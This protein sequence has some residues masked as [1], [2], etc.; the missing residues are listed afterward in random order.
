VTEPLAPIVLRG[1]SKTYGTKKAVF[2]TDLTISQATCVALVGPSGSGKSTLLRLVLG[3]VET[4]TGSV[5]VLGEKMLAER[6]VALRRRI[7]YVIQ[8]GGL[9]P[10]LSARDNA[11]LVA[12]YIGWEESRCEKRLSGLAELV[13]LTGAIW[14]RYPVELSGGERQRVSLVRA[15]ML[16]PEVLLLDEPLGALDPVRR[17]H[18]QDDL[19][20]IFRDLQKTVMLVTHDLAE[21]AYLADEIAVMHEGALLQKGSF[22]ELRARPS[23]EMVS[24]FLRAQRLESA[25]ATR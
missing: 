3:L 17:A 5:M 22:E 13:G 2:P 16:D 19:R 9:F 20:A 8:D 25:E 24:E 4:D 11:T 21:A 1:V 10:H 6:A 7:G 18:L 12:R 23:H 15:L 14:D